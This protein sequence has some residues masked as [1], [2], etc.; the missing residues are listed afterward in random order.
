MKKLFLILTVAALT[1]S[2]GI[3][4]TYQRPEVKTDGLYRD[5]T[6]T[7]DTTSI[8]N[9][10]WRELFT[11]PMLQTLI[12][13][14]LE[15]N[16]NLR[17]ARLRVDQAE[18][19]LKSARLAYIPS[20]S[21]DP[22]GSIG[23]FDNSK[24][25]KTYNVGLSAS[26]EVDIFGRVTNAKKGAKSAFEQS[27]AYRQAVQTKL[28]ATIANS[29][30]TLLML[31]NQVTISE[32]SL[33]SWKK[34]VTMLR[35]LK[36]A[37]QA[38]EAAVA[39]ASSNTLSVEGSILKLKRQINEME[40]SL[41]TLLG[42]SAQAVSRGTLEGQIF[43]SELSIGV[44][45]QM[46]S[47]RPDVR[48]AEFAL[49]Q[50]FYATNEAR[51]AFYPRITLGGSAG[52]TNSAGSFI[53]NPGKLILSAIGSLTQPIFNK[54]LNRAR[55]KIAKSQQEENT[56]KFQQTL[57]DA[58]AEVNNALVQW[59]TARQRLDIDARQVYFLKSA[60]N[61]TQL[62]MTHGHTSYLEVITAQLTLLQSELNQSSDKFEEI[63]GV[64]NLYHALGGGEI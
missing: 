44:P 23:S 11:D 42:T 25:T 32:K 43:P 47:H 7:S 50:S 14:G 46:L 9:L 16:T 48:Q 57:L 31:D 58:G 12:E 40:N 55:L 51:S 15:N 56:I 26:W 13:Q 53:T 45:V 63:Q 5:T 49:A 2:C 24:A 38:N 28:I 62:M 35:A 19:S 36:Q 18:A 8:A 33:E 17:I 10:S 6:A 52:W 20:L 22:Q 64:I 61:S 60:V 29:Y 1:S 41:S 4:K 30:Y 39:Q 34:T 37:G 27:Q 3:Y 54:G 59:Q 21:F